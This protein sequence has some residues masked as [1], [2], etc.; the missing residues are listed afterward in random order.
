MI[1]LQHVS[2]YYGNRVGVK[3]LNLSVPKGQI[4]GLLGPN[5][6]GKTTTM[7]M[8]TGYLEPS[9]GKITIA[10]HDVVSEGMKARRRV[11]YL[12]EN[13]PVYPD[14]TVEGFLKFAARIRE[15][16]RGEVATAIKNVLDRLELADVRHRL[17]G[18]LSK[19]YKQRVGL[20]QAIIHNPD[21]LVLDEPSSGLDPK[22]ITEIRELIRELGKEHTVILSSHILPEVNALCEQ[23]AIINKGQ[24]V[25]VDS[26][27]SL[28]EHIKGTTTLN[29]TVK[30]PRKQVVSTVQG[31]EGV[32]SAKV[33][34]ETDGKIELA[35][36]VK[37]GADPREALFYALAER[38]WPLLELTRR[39]VSL[40]DVFLQLT[41]E[42]SEAE[43]V[44]KLA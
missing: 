21:V 18:K 8:I 5:G 26:P 42:E 41:T 28:A 17:I 4:L 37:K 14:M 40:E 19:G 29:A 32:L 25:A 10:G 7:R 27:D 11:G 9:K 43:E 6:A 35:L 31:L 15:V 1:E 20:A 16:P 39:E 2:K 33:T 36:D 22:Q 30:G 38:D 44:R 12:P 23:V 3:D 24:V 13:P 34:N